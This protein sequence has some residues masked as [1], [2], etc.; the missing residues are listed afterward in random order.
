[1]RENWLIF[2]LDQKLEIDIETLV[3][4]SGQ[5]FMCFV[6]HCHKKFWFWYQTGI[7]PEKVYAGIWPLLEISSLK[8]L[9]LQIWICFTTTK[10]GEYL[11]QTRV[12]EN[13]VLKKCTL[14]LILKLWEFSRVTLANSQTQMLPS[15]S[16]T[17]E[18]RER[19][20]EFFWALVYRPIW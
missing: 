4:H 7:V 20:W 12:F 19:K 2:A 13:L 14:V 3:L 15:F 1:M 10:I 5:K 9:H 11:H 6:V 16:K 18:I 17:L 8:L